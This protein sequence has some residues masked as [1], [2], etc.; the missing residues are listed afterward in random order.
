MLIQLIV[1]ACLLALGFAVGG[2]SERQHLAHLK[3]CEAKT[4]H[5]PATTGLFL[6][7]NPSVGEPSLVS[8]SVVISV[9]YF[10]R[11]VALLRILTGGRIS[12]YESLLSRARRDAILRMKQQA[13]AQGAQ[14]IINVRIETSRLAT[15]R[16]DKGVAGVEV[17]A[18][19]TAVHT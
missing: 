18:Y 3:R 19:G 4:A 8:G 12:S 11:F 17:L 13:I 7:G 5:L 10:K 1:F 6:P 15:G 14:G 9:D 2:Q 16:G